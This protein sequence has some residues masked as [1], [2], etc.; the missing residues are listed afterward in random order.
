MRFLVTGITGFVAPNLA[1]LLI[2]QGHDVVGMVRGSNGNQA[3]ILDI[4]PVDAYNKIKFVYGDLL[5]KESLEKIFNDEDLDGVFHLSAQSHPPT[6]FLL[7]Q[8]TFDTNANGT[9]NLI[10]SIGDRDIAFM[11]CSTSEV[12]GAVPEDAGEI[13]EDFPL[14]PMNPYGVSKASADMYVTER[15]RSLNKRF[16]NTRAFSHTGE[17]RGFNFSI[18]SDAFQIAKIMKGKQEPIIRVGNLSSKRVVMDVRDT[19]R[20]YYLLMLECLRGNLKA[21]ESFNVGGTH[22]YTMEEILDM[23]LD[24]F[25]VEAEK[26]IDEKLWRKIDIPVQICN[27][28]KLRKLTGFEEEYL[29][30]ET[31]TDLV[32]YWSK[33]IC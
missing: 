3:D 10:E 17:R 24:I 26:K 14:C 8:H 33:K 1:N 7:P 15:A 4:V 12:Y 11:N 13:T 31:L 19:A 18:S 23:M 32:N 16:F 28:E 9:I 22:L 5:V 25:S 30:G 21:G 2:A 27:T 29:I 6:S 20:A